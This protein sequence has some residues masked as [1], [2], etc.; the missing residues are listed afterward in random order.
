MEVAPDAGGAQGSK[1]R[2]QRGER[3]GRQSLGRNSA[4]GVVRTGRSQTNSIRTTGFGGQRPP[5]RGKIGKRLIP[6]NAFNYIQ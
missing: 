3:R 1:S 6:A 5:T 2:I 4:V